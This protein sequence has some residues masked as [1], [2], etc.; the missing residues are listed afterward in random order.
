MKGIRP[1]SEI[2]EEALQD[3][4]QAIESGYHKS[5]EGYRRGYLHGWANA[6]TWMTCALERTS[7]TREESLNRLAKWAGEL[8]DAVQDYREQRTYQTYPPSPW[9]LYTSLDDKRLDE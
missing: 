4:K 1:L 3:M 8:D 5:D 9:D 7:L 6:V 2:A